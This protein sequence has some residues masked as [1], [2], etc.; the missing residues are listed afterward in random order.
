MM[1]GLLRTPMLM[2]CLSLA[3]SVAPGILRAQAIDPT[4]GAVAVERGS[5]MPTWVV[6]VLRLVSSTHV[7]PTTGVV[8]SNTGLVVVPTGFADAEDE[9]VVLDGGTDIVRHGRTA[10]IE[11][12]LPMDGVLVLRVSGL[13]REAAVLAEASP[14]DGDVIQLTAYPPAE[15]IAE[16]AATLQ[17]TATLTVLGATAPPAIAGEDPLPNVTGPMIDDCGNLVGLSLAH[18]IQSMQSSPGTRYKW[19]D[20]LLDM[21]TRLGLTPALATCEPYEA[22]SEAADESI[23]EP[24]VLAEPGASE[25]PAEQQ[26]PEPVGEDKTSA[27]P[28]AGKPAGSDDET[29]AEDATDADTERPEDEAP[30]EEPLDLEILP[31]FESALPPPP[32]DESGRDE[33]ASAWPWLLAAALLFG[34]GVVLHRMRRSARPPEPRS[35]LPQPVADGGEAASEVARS[36]ADSRLLLSGRCA[37]GRAVGD[38]CAVNSGAINLTVGRGDAD[39]NIDSRAVSRQHVRLNGTAAALTV[40]DLGSRNGTTVNEVPCLEGEILYVEPGDT[41][42]LGDT[43]LTLQLEPLSADAPDPDDG[44]E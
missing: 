4:E 43:R 39:L 5:A 42:V 35:A 27:E 28:S 1:A 9:I 32:A 44:M 3:V 25:P 18:G 29:Q 17:E 6:P 41:L 10:R 31:P 14:K 7:E 26:A 30:V 36:P 11:R 38:A 13:Q 33:P 16:G 20:G 24:E 15:Q 2:I 22:S 34:A 12:D 23:P 40:T 8:I 37:D 19:Q 21:M